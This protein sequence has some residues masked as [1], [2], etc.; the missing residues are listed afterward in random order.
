[1]YSHDIPRFPRFSRVFP[2]LML[3]PGKT[4][5]NPGKPGEPWEIMG[6][7]GIIVIADVSLIYQSKLMT[8]LIVSTL[9][10]VSVHLPKHHNT[11]ICFWGYTES[12]V[13]FDSPSHL[14]CGS[15]KV[16]FIIK[17][18]PTISSLWNY[19]GFHDGTHR[20]FRRAI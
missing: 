17:L 4:W 18:W 14:P 9:V 8:S 19:F 20:D 16:S 15:G 1:M 2:G 5:E 11:I 12:C 7:L 10:V 6:I 13:V 3:N